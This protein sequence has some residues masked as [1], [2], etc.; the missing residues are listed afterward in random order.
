MI[1]SSKPSGALHN[2]W[3]IH[4]DN[5]LWIQSATAD[6]TNAR[7]KIA[8]SGKGAESLTELFLKADLT[9]IHNTI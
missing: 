6:G 2:P 7:G 8:L 4:M 1:T 5:Y 9:K 3:S